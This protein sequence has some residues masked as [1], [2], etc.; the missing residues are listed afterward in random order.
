[1]SLQETDINALLQKYFLLLESCDD[2]PSLVDCIADDGSMD[3]DKYLKYSEA[4]DDTED[5]LLKLTLQIIEVNGRRNNRPR[6]KRRQCKSLLPYYLADDGTKITIQ[7]TET[8]W[9]MM[10]I[11]GPALGSEKLPFVSKA[12][13]RWWIDGSWLLYRCHERHFV[14]L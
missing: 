5:R 1:M 3:V 2:T 13:R 6:K 14:A 8:P 11:K 12:L 4:D 10:Y 9:Y 7:P